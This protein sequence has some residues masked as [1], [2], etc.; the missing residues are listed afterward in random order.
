M[1]AN[2]S[3]FTY[4][5]R[6]L[7][8]QVAQATL[9][10]TVTVLTP[11]AEAVGGEL[12]L[13]AR[14]VEPAMVRLGLSLLDAAISSDLTAVNT[15][16]GSPQNIRGNR[17]P[18]APRFT[19]SAA[20]EYA[21]AT[22]WG[23]VTPRLEVHHTSA[24]D[25]DLFNNAAARQAAYTLL[26]ASVDLAGP[27]DRV[28]LQLYARNLTDEA[29]RVASVAAGSATGVGLVDFWGAPRTLGARLGVRF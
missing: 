16:T 21:F 3:A 29:Y 27:A 28:V 8:T 22:G 24:Q 26:N 20:G 13:V 10:G 2:V 11:D 5:Y 4:R 19:L 25:F 17:L 14:P 6:R 15:A 9:G 12:E 18:R 23:S 1:I 7:Q